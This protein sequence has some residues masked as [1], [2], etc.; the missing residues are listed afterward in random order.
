MITDSDM[1]PLEF[2]SMCENMHKA[3]STNDH[4]DESGFASFFM[5]LMLCLKMKTTMPTK[6]NQGDRE[7]E[8]VEEI[9]PASVK[10]NSME[11]LHVMG[12]A[13]GLLSSSEEK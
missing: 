12:Q 7:I 11:L 8:V 2:E 10:L 5:L 1:L 9:F 3:D 13:D 4:L 6:E